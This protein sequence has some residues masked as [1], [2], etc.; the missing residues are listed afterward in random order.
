[1]NFYKIF[2]IHF[3][4]RKVEMIVAVLSGII[5]GKNESLQSYID[6]FTQVEVEMEI[7]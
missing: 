4:T 7:A 3:T 6:Q 5:Q 2:T 1:M